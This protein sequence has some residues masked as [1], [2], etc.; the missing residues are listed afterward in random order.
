MSGDVGYEA[1][2]RR[3]QVLREGG[4]FRD[5]CTY[6]RE[7][8]AA[9][10]QQPQPYLELALAL[11]ELPNSRKESLAAV[12]RAVSLEP[13]SARFLGYE[14][15]LLSHFGSHKEALE[16]TTTALQRDPACRIAWLAQANAHTKL[17]NWY[18]AE[19]AARRMLELNA[20]DTAAM[21]LLAQAL[22][23][24][25]K[26]KESREVI[27][28][29]LARIP[30]DDFAQTNAGFEALNAGDHVRAKCHFLAALRVNPHSDHARR[31]LLQ[32]LRARIWFYRVNLRIFDFYGDLRQKSIWLQMLVAFLLVGTGG[33][34]LILWTMYILLSFTLQP[35]SNFFLLLEPV[36]RRALTRKERNWAFV[37]GA[38]SALALFF[39]TRYRALHFFAYVWGAYLGLFALGVYLPQALD[40]VRF[41]RERRAVGKSASPPADD[42]GA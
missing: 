34:V 26:H 32:S 23:L 28:R 38:L 9:D 29:I 17:R 22:R 4:R 2:L 3:G 31:G 19:M 14:A 1:N 35:V 41:W 5:A 20:E 6:L 7:A 30:E 25:G 36:G 37:T 8:I 40:A 12:A 16:K 21:N 42:R 24:G 18:L 33:A 11:A 10:P 27:T 13:N 15:Y 39:L